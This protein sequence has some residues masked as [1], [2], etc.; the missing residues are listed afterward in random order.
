MGHC[1]GPSSPRDAGVEPLESCTRGLPWYVRTVLEKFGFALKWILQSKTSTLRVG[2]G[3][4]GQKGFIS[5][6]QH[7]LNVAGDSAKTLSVLR[8]MGGVVDDFGLRS[9]Q[10]RRRPPLKI[11]P[12]LGV[13]NSFSKNHGHVTL[14]K[15]YQIDELTNQTLQSHVSYTHGPSAIEI[16]H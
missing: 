7:S 13:H 2:L 6:E 8:N 14:P 16:S 3:Q 11:P 5:G 15:S 4:N 10:M 12:V 9:V 1:G